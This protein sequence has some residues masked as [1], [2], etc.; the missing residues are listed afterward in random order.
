[1]NLLAAGNGE[2][3]VWTKQATAIDA[4]DLAKSDSLMLLPVSWFPTLREVL[5]PTGSVRL[6]WM[7]RCRLPLKG[8][9][10]NRRCPAHSLARV[11][12]RL[13]TAPDIPITHA[14]GVGDGRTGG[15]SRVSG[16]VVGER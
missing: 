10:A 11:R 9:I 16:G 15:H 4:E 5:Q 6:S 13:P 3:P 7:D 14:P 2:L 12:R 8:R 1:M